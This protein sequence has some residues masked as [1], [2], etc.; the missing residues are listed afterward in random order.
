MLLTTHLKGFNLILCLS[1]CR[2][3]TMF[4]FFYLQIYDIGKG[5]EMPITGIQFH[6]VETSTKYFIFVTTPT[7]L[8]QFMGHAI[9]MDGKP[10]LQSVFYQYLNMPDTAFQEIPSTLK[11]SKLQFHFDRNEIPKTFAWLTGPGI[12]YGQVGL[13]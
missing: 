1:K 5:T 3:L 4:Q 13:D 12:F 6:R 7:R 10:S 8:Y 11:Y 2:Y 9:T